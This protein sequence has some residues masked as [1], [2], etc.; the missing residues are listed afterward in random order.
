[1]AVAY[2]NTASATG[3]GGGAS[4]SASHLLAAAGNN[5]ILVAV[6]F[7]MGP[8][9]AATKF[10]SVLCNGAAPAGQLTPDVEYNRYGNY[11]SVSVYYW[12]E[13]NLPAN[14]TPTSYNVTATSATGQWNGH[15]AT[16]SYTGVAQT[17]PS[18]TGR[19]SAQD[20]TSSSVSLT[21]TAVNS[22]IVDAV[23]VVTATV[24]SVTPTAGQTE[25]QDI[26][27]TGSYRLGVGYEAVGATASYSQTWSWTNTSTFNMSFALA[28]A[29]ATAS[30]AVNV[31]VANLRSGNSGTPISHPLTNKANR[32]VLVFI[33]QE[34]TTQAT[35]VTYNSVAMTRVVYS[36]SAVGTGNASS[37]WMILNSQLP[38][39]AGSYSV[40]VSGLGATAGVSV[41]EINNVA[42]VIPTGSA[43]DT[44]E[45]GAVS[46]TT[47]TVT[48]PSG[49]SLAM[50]CAGHGNDPT[51]F[52]ATPSGTGTWT[53]LFTRLNPPTSAHFV[54]AYQA[55]SSSGAKNYTE[56]SAAAWNRAS[57]CLAI[58]AGFVASSANSPFFGCTF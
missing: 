17:V 33:D 45:T 1:M 11:G 46:T 43:I 20:A 41:V 34:S 5:R 4:Y 7:G 58:F 22:V 6:F 2:D 31:E 14:G 29:P 9:N 8:S 40:A 28:L 52:N 55:F 18:A 23:A 32:G 47:A 19:S 54:G 42:Q 35:G 15:L 16:V 38:V 25:V 57:Q 50:G 30:S 27:A 48:A 49:E 10:S 21:T 37:I 13:A 12:L 44:N 51:P 24:A 53:R 39:A 36:T 3:G 26:G 56:T